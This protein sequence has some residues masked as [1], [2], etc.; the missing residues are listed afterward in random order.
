MT[1]SM[2]YK[3]QGVVANKLQSETF[4]KGEK[5]DEIA[6]Y[7]YNYKLNADP[8]NAGQYLA[9]TLKSTTEYLYG[10]GFLNADN[11]LVLIFRL[12]QRCR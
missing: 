1:K 12:R 8:V 2:T 6:D 10:S 4:Y 11:S 9:P 7:S 3:D 5:S